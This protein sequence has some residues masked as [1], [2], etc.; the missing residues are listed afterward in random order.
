MDAVNVSRL[1][2][3]PSGQLGLFQQGKAPA[4]VTG[5]C[6]GAQGTLRMSKK[7]S[8]DSLLRPQVSKLDLD[9]LK[10]VAMGDLLK[11]S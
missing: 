1:I 6:F 2:F 11:Y 10:I 4:L 8:S 3:P 5:I 9:L 7:R